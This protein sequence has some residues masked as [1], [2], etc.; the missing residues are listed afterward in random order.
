MRIAL[1]AGLALFL[2]SATVASAPARTVSDCSR[3]STGL[4]PLNELKA[5]R[6][7]GYQGGLYPGGKNVPSKPYLS[8]GLAASKRVHGRV[9][10]LSIGMSNTTQEF[11]T[12]MRVAR[13]DRDLN[14]SLTIVD[15]AQG[16]QDAVRISDPLA[17][18][19]LNV[20]RRLAAANV[21]RGDVQVVWLKEA[22]ARPTETFPMD[23]RRLQTLLRTIVN[24]LDVRF[25]NLRLVYVS[26][27]VYAGYASTPLNP[28]P[29]AYQSGFAVKWL[30]ADRIAGR[31]KGPWVGWGPYLW[32]DGT[33]TRADGLTWS[34]SDLQQDG[35]HPSETGRA[36]VAERLL[37]FLK[38]SPTSKSWFLG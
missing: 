31:I 24:I 32:A 38:T 18:F 27:R 28:E 14:S 4:V 13:N 19:W 29:Y 10:L 1:G 6:Y 22:I 15:G 23:G 26:S 33:K 21:T 30:V 37:R 8:Q 25:P 2:L 17:P 35:T 34:C 5:K 11:S 12:F 16:A 36:K 9:V 3:T 20:D 7:R